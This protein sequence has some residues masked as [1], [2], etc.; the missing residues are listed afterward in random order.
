MSRL[1]AVG[2]GY[3]A[4]ALAT[5][6]AK[7]HWTITGTARTEGGLAA[8]RS[9]GFEAAP[10]NGEEPSPALGA[11]LQ[12]ATHLLLSAPPEAKGDPLL[13]YHR[14]DLLAAP[15][16]RWIGYLST[17]GV[18]GDHAGAWI[19]E[20][21]PPQPRSARSQ[22][23]VAA[24]REWLDLAAAGGIPAAIFRLSGIYGPG[25]N[26]LLKL[27]AG[28]ERRLYKPDQVFNRIHVEDIVSAVDA[29]IAR[30]IG[31]IFNVADDEP[32]PP[33]D[34]IAFAADL[35]GMEPPPLVDWRTADL[36][37]MA[38]SFWT[39]N[40]RVRNARIKDVLGVTL[41]YPTYREGLRALLGQAKAPSRQD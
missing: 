38:K 37:P 18:Y 14:A 12:E 39:E 36:S 16:L 35:L 2:L 20:S 27:R 31:G 29:S 9:L 5:R 3:S 10:F 32:N 26:T 15:R 4:T 7:Q 33:Q 1:L 30:D 13:T 40:K 41:C 11:G 21:T 22:W 6:L 17:I 19:D 28:T 25:R 34:V 24:E 23:R 8:I